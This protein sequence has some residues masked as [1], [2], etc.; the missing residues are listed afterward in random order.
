MMQREEK[1]RKEKEKE[2]KGKKRGKR[3][4]KDHVKKKRKGRKKGR[5]TKGCRSRSG[6]R[7]PCRSARRGRLERF[8]DRGRERGIRAL[9]ARYGRRGVR[10]LRR[11]RAHA[12]EQGTREHPSRTPEVVWA[13]S[14]RYLVTTPGTLALQIYHLK[15][16]HSLQSLL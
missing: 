13:G 12:A 8:A 1:E 10:A 2:R 3:K 11:A 4:R 9:R 14:F 16:S 5:E 7:R 15:T 6:A